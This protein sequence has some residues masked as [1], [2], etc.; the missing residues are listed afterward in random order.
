[1]ALFKRTNL[2]D[3]GLTDEQI[4]YV[5]TES[6]RALGDYELKSNIQAQIDEAV[7]AVKPAEVNVL[8]SAEYLSLMAENEKLKAFGTEDFA[9]VKAPYKDMVWDKLDH[10]AEHKP[11]NEQ[12]TELSTTMPDLFSLQ[13]EEQKATP[14]FAG[15][16]AGT[17]PKGDEA[18]SFG[19]I[20][21]FVPNK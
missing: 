9:M 18:P 8:E 16:T 14:Q 10:G 6:G 7:K 20:W 12:L 3:K 19:K 13:T 17:M 2:K 21:G 15:G 5:M 11:Y 1:M 4:E